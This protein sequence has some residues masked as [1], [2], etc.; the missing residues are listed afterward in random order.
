MHF[1][2]TLTD[3]LKYKKLLKALLQGYF[4]SKRF[5]IMEIIDFFNQFH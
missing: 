1:E 4:N 5:R 3:K 2:S